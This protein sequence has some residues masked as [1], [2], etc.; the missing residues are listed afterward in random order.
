LALVSA[1]SLVPFASLQQQLKL[2]DLALQVLALWELVELLVHLVEP[3]V[4]ELAGSPEVEQP[5]W[6][7][8]AWH[9]EQQE[10]LS[11]VAAYWAS[12][13]KQ[14]KRLEPRRVLVRSPLEPWLEIL[15]V[16]QCELA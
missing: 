5:V 10:P 8:E 9:L 16:G 7:L 6:W 3:S 14:P 15:V 4:P 13:E 12:Y 1:R 11:V 2:L